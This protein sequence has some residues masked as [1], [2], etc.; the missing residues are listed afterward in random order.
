MTNNSQKIEVS[1]SGMGGSIL[2]LVLTF[3]AG[4]IWHGGT[5]EAGFSYT[6]FILCVACIAIVCCV[7]F[8]GLF[9]AF[10]FV[11]GWDKFIGAFTY[12]DTTHAS[13][14]LMG[15]VMIVGGLIINVFLMLCIILWIVTEFFD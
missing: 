9:V 10:I 14:I 13:V 4:W 15:R 3:M 12:L 7:P 5:I 2:F 8:L 1:N 6:I 11:S